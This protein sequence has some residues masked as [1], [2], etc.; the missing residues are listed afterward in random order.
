MT[1]VPYHRLDVQQTTN[2]AVTL[3]NICDRHGTT[4]P[5]GYATN[6]R[7]LSYPEYRHPQMKVTIR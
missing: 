7:T 4:A 1:P 5:G 3:G 6:I 2:D